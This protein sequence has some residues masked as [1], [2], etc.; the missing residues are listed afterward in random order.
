MN[1]NNTMS[2]S[3]SFANLVSTQREHY[4]VDDAIDIIISMDKT[5]SHI[6]TRKTS[7]CRTKLKKTRIMKRRNE[8]NLRHLHHNLH[9]PRQHLC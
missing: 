6:L 5:P 2:N 7:K 9:P 3:V 1:I 8:Q 4:A